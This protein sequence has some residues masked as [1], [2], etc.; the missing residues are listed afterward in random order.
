LIERLNISATRDD[1]LWSS[2]KK[3]CAWLGM[4]VFAE[5]QKVKDQGGGWSG[6]LKTLVLSGTFSIFFPSYRAFSFEAANP[7]LEKNALD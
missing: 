5:Q 1:E 6:R 3:A 2:L 4:S 7:C